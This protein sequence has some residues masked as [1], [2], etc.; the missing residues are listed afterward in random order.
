[1]IQDIYPLSPLQEGLYYHWL[2]KPGS[3]AYF[4]QVSCGIEGHLDIT[5]LEKSYHTLVL[6]H[7]VLRTFFSSD[8]DKKVLQIVKKEVPSTFT[9]KDVSKDPSFS[10]KDFMASDKARG[11]DLHKDSQM[12]LTVFSLDANNFELVWSHHHILM[13]GWCVGILINE[14]FSIYYGLIEGR[15]AKLDKIVPYSEYIKWIS[16]LNPKESLSY[17]RNYLNEYDTVSSLPKL[18]GNK[19]EINRFKNTGFALSDELNNKVQALCKEIQVTENTFILA[20]WGILLA[21]YNNSTDAVFGSVVS[22]RPGHIDGIEHMV[23]LFINTIPVRIRT[24]AGTNVKDLLKNIQTHSIEAGNHHFTQLAEIQAESSLGGGLFNHILQFQNYPVQKMVEDRIDT[25]SSHK[26]FSVKSFEAFEQNNYDLTIIAIPG[27]NTSISFFYNE[28]VYKSEIIENVKNNLLYLI[29]QVVQDPGKNVANLDCM[30]PNE[31][32]LLLSEFNNCHANYPS[33]NVISLFENWAGKMN[34]KVAIVCNGKSLSYKELSQRSSVLANFLKD[35]F[36]LKPGQL[37]GILMDRSDNMIVSLLGVLKA[38]G[39]YVPIDPQLPE[40]RKKYII[41]DTATQVLIT[42]SDYLKEVAFYKDVLLDIETILNGTQL[43]P[44]FVCSEIGG[45]S[46]AY[47]IYTSGSTG[48][49]KGVMVNHKA[50]AN[51]IQAQQD[52]INLSAGN[53]CLQFFSSSFDVSVFEIFVALCTGS[54]L[55]II[56]DEHKKDSLIFESFIRNND[57]EVVTL[58]ASYLN[59]LSF[60]NTPA[61]KKLITGGESPSI[62]KILQLSNKLDYYNAYGPT[63]VSICSSIY[64]INK[65][66]VKELSSVPIG[67]PLANVNMYV[68]DGSNK[69]LPMGAVGEIAIG[70]AGLASGYLNNPQLS[71]EKFVDNQYVANQKMYK[72]GDIGRWLSDGNMEFIGRKDNQVKIRGYRIEIGEIENAIQMHPSVGANIVVAKENNEGYKELV[73][74]LTA[75]TELNIPDIKN[76]LSTLLPEYMIPGHFV[77]MNQ[78]PLTSNGKID[79]KKLPDPSDLQL[80]DSREHI[81]TSSETEKILIEIW[82]E[83]L[84]RKNVSITDNFFDL[85]GHSLKATALASRIYKRLEVRISLKDLFANPVLEAQ[86]K[87]I[88]KSKKTDFIEIKQA[89][90]KK[91]YP[92][93]AAQKR[94][95]F[96]QELDPDSTSYNIPIVYYIGKTADKEKLERSL[97]QLINRHESLRTSFVKIDGIAFQRINKNVQLQFETY[98]CDLNN[99]K[100][101]MRS[102]VKPFDFNAPSLMRSALVEVENFGFAW[103]LDIH[104]I[105][106]DGTS[107]EVLTDDFIRFYQGKEL[108]SLKLQYHDY[109]E[110]QNNMI[111]EGKLESQKEYWVSKFSDNIPRLDFPADKL[112]PPVFTFEGKNFDFE[113]A[114]ELSAKIRQFCK[115]YNTTLQMTMISVLNVVFAKYT[116]REDITIGF[117]IAGRRHP[118]LERI[119]GMFVN[120]LVT[121]N[122]PEGHKSFIEFNKEIISNCLTAYENQDFQFEDLVDSLKLER[123]PSRNPIFDINVIVQNFEKSKADIS[124]IT[125]RNIN[126]NLES[127]LMSSWSGSGTSKFDMTWFVVERGENIAIN[128]EYYS[129]IYNRETIE[130]LSKHFKHILKVLLDTPDVLLSDV[131]MLTVEEEVALLNNYAHGEKYDY[132]FE[133]TL[134][135]LFEKQCTLKKD[136]IAVL[137]DEGSLKYGEL[138]ANANQ[139]ANFLIEQKI[140]TEAKIGI[141]QKRSKELVVSI[142]AVL[143]AG[144]AYVPLDSEYP[145]DRLMQMVKDSGIEILLSDREN[146][147]FAN[148]LMWRSGKIKCLVCTDSKNVYNEKLVVRNE[149]M[150]KELWDHVGN[151]STDLISGGGWMSSYTGEYF[152]N[153]EMEEY[154]EN[155]YLKLKKYLRKDARVLEIGCSSGLTMFK[156]APEVGMYLG[157]D[158]SSSILARTQQVVNEKGLKNIKLEC[159]SADQVDSISENDFDIIIINSVV[160]SFNGHNYLWNVIKKITDKVSDKGIIFFGDIMDA[161]KQE[162]LVH[163]LQEFQRNNPGKGYRTKTDWSNELFLSQNYFADL[164]HYGIGVSEV[165]CSNKIHTVSNELTRYRYDAVL[166][167]NKLA[168]NKFDGDKLSKCL[169]DLSTVNKYPVISPAVPVTGNNLAYIIYTSGSTGKPKGVMIEHKGVINYIYWVLKDIV[170]ERESGRFALFTS[171]SFDLTVTSIF[172]PL[173]KGDAVKIYGT[174]DVA[175]NVKLL[176]EGNGHEDVVKLTPSHISLIDGLNAQVFPF[177]K[178]IVGGEEL[179]PTQVKTLKTLNPQVKIYNEYGPTESTVGCIAWEVSGDTIFIGKPIMN[180]S[181]YILGTAMEIVP[182]GVIGEIFIGG[183]GLA[184]GYLNNQEITNEKFIVNPYE[185]NERLYKTG[186][187][188]R[189]LLEGNIEFLGRKDD[190]VKIRGHRIELGEIEKA[191]EYYPSVVSVTVIVKTNEKDEKNLIAYVVAK[192]K[193]IVSDIREDLNHRLPAY[194]IPAHFIQ[195]EKMPLTYNGKIDKKR[196]LLIDNLTVDSITE[197]L[198]P[199]NETEMKVLEIWQKVLGFENIGVTSSFFEL[200]GHSLKAIVITSKIEKE[201]GVKIKISEVFSNPTIEHLSNIIRAAEWVKSPQKEDTEQRTI[202]EL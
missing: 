105:V 62:E 185:K 63:E 22:G 97:N 98:Q 42:N 129:A 93:S 146:I 2:S 165:D 149:L 133:S 67:K 172:A 104:H 81:V 47:I 46:L 159:L 82:E 90:E 164:V 4:E 14:F 170:T 64:K 137:D 197:Y 117:G 161:D 94:L 75:K 35:K 40:Q 37:V 113:I 134:H 174:P 36:G 162:A 8:V 187:L 199:R 85:G 72:T 13:D 123:D 92:L 17:W 33:H 69:I 11:F 10:L 116:G 71:A 151:A 156:V 100:L 169:Y 54:S 179:K 18:P 126:S 112:R 102:F 160:Q 195:V 96:L 166:K 194:M 24:N 83:L 148:R 15:P 27:Q 77:Q 101:F 147:E 60:E 30:T 158:L 55:Y 99:F 5:L 198:A 68:I 59:S 150:R 80:E 51:S 127:E 139:L 145:E 76:H 142:L 118:D 122:F 155:T 144:A 12:R 106:A 43:S 192:E 84:N 200:G 181:V 38:G 9:Y 89:E 88:D 20:L 177:K 152:S 190:Q 74:Y 153:Q 73:A 7:P 1:M 78:L 132:P 45:A 58:P 34:D 25:I 171:V 136:S 188:G 65:G 91:Y 52:V 173:L 114:P 163:D 154:S 110:W 39:V 49:P 79:R 184:R 111:L 23:G 86:A 16:G 61:L 140:Q 109:S 108:P 57:I 50:L 193:L 48:I 6:R 56:S 66:G 201:F 191:I 32:E 107:T 196:L 44:S 143:K 19:N 180:T 178:V 28:K 21:K 168:K 176:L 141:L 157:V 124:E 95:F 119:V 70:G 3:E 103:V 31:R 53:R 189:W 120:T 167:M 26:K 183:A 138:N 115:K 135:E 41:K 87:I 182:A 125:G 202:I 29:Q 121:R 131:K 128:I 175:D 130:K 186:D